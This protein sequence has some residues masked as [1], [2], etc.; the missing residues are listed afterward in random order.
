MKFVKYT[1]KVPK[2]NSQNENEYNEYNEFIFYTLDEV[3]KFLDAKE[4]SIY[5]IIAGEYKCTHK[6]SMKLKGIIITKED[7]PKK[8]RE[9]LKKKYGCNSDNDI[10]KKKEEETKKISEEFQKELLNKYQSVA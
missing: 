8:F 2:I 1:V 6:R 9:E 4:S 10:K 5:K 3:C 7:L